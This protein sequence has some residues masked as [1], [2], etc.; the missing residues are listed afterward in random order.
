M[1]KI[2][3][4]LWKGF[5]KAVTGKGTITGAEPVPGGTTYSFRDESGLDWN[6]SLRPKIAYVIG[7]D[8]VG[9]SRRSLDGQLLLTTWLF[10]II[11]RSIEHLRNIGW[12]S[13][14][15][16]CVLIPTGDGAM[17]VIDDDTLLQVATALIYHI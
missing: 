12:I 11:R 16:P 17:I 7:L 5:G 8:T 2:D 14:S 10:S 13:N 6:L 9:Y 1:S 4:E 15:Q 3:E